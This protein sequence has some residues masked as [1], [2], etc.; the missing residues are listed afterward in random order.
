L[1]IILE[2]LAKSNFGR[3]DMKFLHE[4]IKFFKKIINYLASACME[5]N[6]IVDKLTW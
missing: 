3:I 1:F 4:K 6:K 2:A 5:R